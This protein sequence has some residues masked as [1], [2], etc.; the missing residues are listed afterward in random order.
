MPES[1]GRD[2]GEKMGCGVARCSMGEDGLATGGLTG[3][4]YTWRVLAEEGVG[5]ARR[6]GMSKG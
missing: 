1:A 6:E 2:W 5:V 3:I 4:Y